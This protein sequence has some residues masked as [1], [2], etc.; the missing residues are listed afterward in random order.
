MMFQTQKIEIRTAEFEQD[1]LCQGSQKVWLLGKFLDYSLIIH[2]S[3]DYSV[4]IVIIQWLLMIIHDYS[5]QI[6]IIH[7]K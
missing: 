2:D 4:I 3:R 7:R 5:T 1:K 6:M